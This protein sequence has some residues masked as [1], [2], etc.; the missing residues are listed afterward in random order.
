MTEDFC[1]S[2][3][4]LF[5]VHG[6]A[7]SDNRCLVSNLFDVSSKSTVEEMSQKTEIKIPWGSGIVGHV[8]QSGKPVN[9]EDCYKDSRFNQE[10]LIVTSLSNRDGPSAVL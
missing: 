1:C 10:V 7:G 9:I 4:S 2:R 6:E 8:A 3:C 5:L